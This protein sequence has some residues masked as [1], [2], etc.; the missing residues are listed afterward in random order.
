[1]LTMCHQLGLNW[2]FPTLKYCFIGLL[3][4]KCSEL[5]IKVG[6]AHNSFEFGTTTGTRSLRSNVDCVRLKHKKIKTNLGKNSF[7]FAG[8]QI[9]NFIPYEYKQVN[10]FVF[11]KHMKF[12]INWDN[13]KL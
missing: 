11:K 9:W 4:T 5:L 8:C 6:H 13:L 12:S 3:L 2:A 1:M 10:H 7:D